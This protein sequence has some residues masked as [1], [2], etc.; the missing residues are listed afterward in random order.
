MAR[1]GVSD[2]EGY[3]DR[4]AGDADALADLL[5]EVTVGETYFFREPAHFAFIRREVLPD[6][7]RRRC[8]RAVQLPRTC[9]PGRRP[10]RSSSRSREGKW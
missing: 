9:R 2:P 10:R 8:C 6:L 3:R 4:V 7:R 5:A 1:A